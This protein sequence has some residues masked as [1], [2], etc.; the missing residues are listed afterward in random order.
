MPYFALIVNCYFFL[1]FFRF[2]YLQEQA[3][4]STTLFIIS[5]QCSAAKY[6]AVLYSSGHKC[7]TNLP[8]YQRFMV[9]LRQD[10]KY[11]LYQ[12]DMSIKLSIIT[13]EKEITNLIFKK[14]KK[15]IPLHIPEVPSDK[16]FL[17]LFTPRATLSAFPQSAVLI[18]GPFYFTLNLSLVQSS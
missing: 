18:G 4:R 6:W 16:N 13:N 17:F 2:N 9:I 11:K 5:S 14:V 12:V 8:P 7:W 3:K 10:F 1:S 15:V